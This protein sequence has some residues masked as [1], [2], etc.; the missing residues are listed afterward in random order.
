[1]PRANRRSINARIARY[2]LRTLGAGASLPP[3]DPIRRV[4][5][6]T[7]E[8]YQ[9]TAPTEPAKYDAGRAVE[10]AIRLGHTANR[11]AASLAEFG[12]DLSASAEWVQSLG[13]AEH[14]LDQALGVAV[15]DDLA[16]LPFTGYEASGPEYVELNGGGGDDPFPGDP[17]GTALYR[18]SGVDQD[19]DAGLVRY[20]AM[21][22]DRDAI[23]EAARAFRIVADAY[24]ETF[25][26]LPDETVADA[27]KMATAVLDAAV[28]GNGR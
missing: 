28:G 20:Q 12:D 23:L 21:T 22:A 3:T 16:D 8:S 25:G 24:R 10:L 14:A 4:P 2:G 7:S 26:E 15:D 18:Y 1:M 6:E 11:L 27:L 17:I 5:V 19:A 13:D 9:T